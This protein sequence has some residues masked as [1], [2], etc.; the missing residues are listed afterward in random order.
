MGKRAVVLTSRGDYGYDGGKVVGK[1]HVE[2][3]VFIALGY[4][5][6]TRTHSIAV[7]YDECRARRGCAGGVNAAG[8]LSF[9]PC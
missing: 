1:N 3:S 5:G 7:E 4:L 2:P 6:I 9:R 8:R